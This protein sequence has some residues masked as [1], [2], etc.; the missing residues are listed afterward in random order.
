MY[1]YRDQS[2]KVIDFDVNPSGF[3]TSSFFDHL[4]N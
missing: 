2:L 1:M 4:F 3:I